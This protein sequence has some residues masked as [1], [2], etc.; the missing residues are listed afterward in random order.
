MGYP[1]ET[2][3]SS[4]EPAR[5]RQVITKVLGIASSACGCTNFPALSIKLFGEA[6]QGLFFRLERPLET[7]LEVK[8]YHVPIC[9]ISEVVNNVKHETVLKGG[10]LGVLN[11]NISFNGQKWTLPLQVWNEMTSLVR[12]A[13]QKHQPDYF[14]DPAAAVIFMS[15]KVKP[16][17]LLR[18]G[19]PAEALA[20]AGP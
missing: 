15:R 6:N 12:Q 19:L 8:T 13:Y 2:R 1:I 9:Q 3:S 10:A 20:K 14:A 17:K 18:D 11:E 7:G 16:L 5:Q 4:V